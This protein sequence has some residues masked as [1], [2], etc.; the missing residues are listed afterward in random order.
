MEHKH[1]PG[2]WFRK[3][4]TVYGLN[5]SGFNRFSALVQDAHTCDEELEANAQLMAASPELLEA[6]VKAQE[7]INWMLNT[8][9]TLNGHC[10]DYIDATIAK[11]TGEQK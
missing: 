9:Q 11:A 6:L 7:D 5:G 1:T 3:G 10:F 2:K 8:G 4:L